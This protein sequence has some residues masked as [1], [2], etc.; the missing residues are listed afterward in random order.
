METQL[1]AEL[2]QRVD[3]WIRDQARNFNVSID[4]YPDSITRYGNWLH[5]PVAAKLR[6]DAYARAS[7]LQ[8]IEDVWDASKFGGIHLLLVPTKPAVPSKDESYEKPGNLL[9]RQHLLL[10]RIGEEGGDSVTEQ[11]FQLIRSEWEETLEEMGKLY[12][13]LASGVV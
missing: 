5:V 4:T 6:G 8:Q 2:T 7:L 13:S 10:D 3:D 1:D 9:K 12:P 11:R